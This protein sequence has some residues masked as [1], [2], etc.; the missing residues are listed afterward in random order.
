MD[1]SREYREDEETDNQTR[2]PREQSEFQE[3]AI[4]TETSSADI[5]RIQ[6]SMIESPKDAQ[7]ENISGEEF[8]EDIREWLYRNDSNLAASDSSPS[9]TA[10]E[11]SM[12]WRD[13]DNPSARGSNF[14]KWCNANLMDDRAERL[15]VPSEQNDNLNLSAQSRLSDD[16]WAR[17]NAIWDMKCG[18]EQGNI[19]I[20]Q[21]SDY[22]KMLNEGQV[23]ALKDGH[24]Q[25]QNIESINYLF[26]T[27]EGAL[28][29]QELIESTG[30]ERIFVWYLD[31]DNQPRLLQNEDAQ[32]Y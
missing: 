25:I 14:E 28:N 24:E 8:D 1:Y 20:S 4:S 18:Y 10:T 6:E 5:R 26:D 27:K 16:Y 7:L 19:D 17:D 23:T 11:R 15:R 22:Q 9:E 32:R 31:N 29:N 2:K 30:S 21:L 12:P 13:A 3:R